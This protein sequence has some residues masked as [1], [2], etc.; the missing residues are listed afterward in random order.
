MKSFYLPTCAL[1]AVFLLALQLGPQDALAQEISVYQYRHVPAEH[2]AE[3][4][5]RETTYW[6]QVA[7]KAVDED[8]LEF[9][10]LLQK[11]G[12]YDLQNSSNF[13]FI[14]TF[15]DIDAS[16]GI[17]NASAV[18]PDY[19]I[20]MME[21]G[22]LSTVT[23]M[24]YVRPENFVQAS[25]A[26]PPDDFNYVG[27]V[28]HNASNSSELIALENEHWAPFI[29]AAM[30]DK[31]TTQVAWGNATIL[32][33]LGEDIKANTISFDLYPSLKEALDPTWDEDTVFPDDGLAKINEL[34]LN[35]R[36]TVIYR[37]VQVVA[38]PPEQ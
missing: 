23:S 33:P 15:E 7:Q 26:V 5:E 36:G 25:D 28:Y 31:K 17:W 32:S 38:A 18:F 24:F 8:K 1:F 21:T 37:I 2:V 16:G 27:F 19:P 10:A 6:S 3:F 20:E 13:L 12:G 22:S 34:E 35:R 9:W 29:K 14:N 4:I 11:V 30:D